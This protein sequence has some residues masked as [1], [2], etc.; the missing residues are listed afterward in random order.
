MDG[1]VA[2]L[3]WLGDGEHPRVRLRQRKCL[4]RHE[5]GYAVSREGDGTKGW[6][7]SEQE[8]KGGAKKG[9]ISKITTSKE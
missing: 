4:Q 7:L 8:G 2:V 5:D 1:P 3:Y 6:R 9:G